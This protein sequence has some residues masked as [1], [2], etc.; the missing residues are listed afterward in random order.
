MYEYA[1]VTLRVRGPVL[2]CVLK[3]SSVAV[4]TLTANTVAIGYDTVVRRL[5]LVS[6]VLYV[7]P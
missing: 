7:T 4:I 1:I 3:V 6:T 2:F 5:T